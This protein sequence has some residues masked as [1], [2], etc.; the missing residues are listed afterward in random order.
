MW[1]ITKVLIRQLF[2]PHILDAFFAVGMNSIIV[3]VGHDLLGAFFPFA[4]YNQEKS[5]MTFLAANLV[6]VTLW[7]LISYYWFALKFFVKI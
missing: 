1:V 7:L 5:H 6:A 4:V 2:L 3:Y